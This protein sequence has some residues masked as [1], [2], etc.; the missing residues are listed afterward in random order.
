MKNM[1]LNV[2]IASVGFLDCL[3]SKSIKYSKFSMKFVSSFVDL[4]LFLFEKIYYVTS[5]RSGFLCS[6]FDD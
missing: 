6:R 5:E 4:V 2:L 1:I 3:A